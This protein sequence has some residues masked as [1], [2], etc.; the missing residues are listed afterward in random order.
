MTLAPQEQ[1]MRT[2]ETRIIS[3]S[4]VGKLDSGELLAGVSTPTASPAEATISDEAV[5]TSA[6]TILGK[7][8]AIGQAVQFKVTGAAANTYTITVTA[9]SDSSPAQTLVATLTLVVT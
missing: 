4:F 9:T 8:V 2:T 3:V 7:P 6:L 5:N 1:A